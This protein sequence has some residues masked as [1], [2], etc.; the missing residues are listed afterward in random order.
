[1]RQADHLDAHDLLAF[2]DAAPTPY[3]AVEEVTRRLDAAGY[4]AWQ[5]T[6]AWTAG[7]GTRAYTVRGGGSIIA[8]EVGTEPLAEAGL[9]IVGAHTDSPNLRLK[10]RPDRVAEGLR[11]LEVVPYGG[12]LL[13]TWFDRDCSIAGQVVVRDGERA[14]PVL[15]RFDQPLV[16]VANLAIHLQRELRKDGFQPNTQQHVAPILGLEGAP[17]LV[18]LLLPRLEAALGH[19][20]AE[21][22]LLGWDL[23]LYDV[24]P[25]ALSGPQEEMVHASRLDNLGSCHAAVSAL[26]SLSGTPAPFTR[27]IALWDHEEVGSG[28]A[29]GARGTF[30]P[31]VIARLAPDAE[32][33]RRAIQRSTLLSVDMA[34]GAHPNYAD[35]H[36]GNHKPL[37]GQG[38]VIKHNINQRYATNAETAG[39]FRGLCQRASVPC[40]DFV[41]RNDMPCGSTIG[42]LSATLLGMSTVDVGNA[43]LSMHSVR[44]MTAAIDI[45]RMIAVLRAWFEAK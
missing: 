3:H 11:L 1:M 10:P 45:P 44:E 31:D 29:T 39:L 24:Q 13:H 42:P 23:M 21:D 19:A 30:L 38:P 17:D 4:V 27:V 43:M 22:D 16:R 25:A 32:A 12:L 36:D 40:Q 33:R 7:P 15:V 6:D 37:L 18:A 8:F 34:H 41:V 20:V 28:S 5:E 2:I 35:K 26:T 14:R 9:H